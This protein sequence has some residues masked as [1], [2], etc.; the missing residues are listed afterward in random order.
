MSKAAS[1]STSVARVEPTGTR[2]REEVVD[3]HLHT[4]GTVDRVADVLGAA[5][6]EF[7]AVAL[8]EQLTERGD[9]AQRFLQIVGCDIGELLELGVGPPQLDCL[10]VEDRPGRTRRVE[11]VND[12]L[13]HVLDIGRD[14]PDVF[15]PPW[16][17]AFA[18]VALGDSP[19]RRGER[20]QRAGDRPSHQ[21]RQQHGHD[22][23]RQD[24]GY[25]HPIT[26]SAH[27]CELIDACAVRRTDVCSACR[28]VL[29]D[30]RIR[31]SRAPPSQC[32][33]R[34]GRPVLR[35]R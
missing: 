15:R 27:A 4:L 6:I 22:E 19:T 1:R 33:R 12:P 2:E 35:W 32:R 17:D 25:Q 18:E 31:P 24:Q 8:L 14:S 5:L 23:E 34:W 30:Y 7:V 13:P 26:P 16:R 21:H 10:L 3:Q 9:L 29:G 20:G 28:I 11:I